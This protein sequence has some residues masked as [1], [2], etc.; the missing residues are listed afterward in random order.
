MPTIQDELGADG[1]D[2]LWIVNSFQLLLGALLLVGGSLG[3]LYGRKRIYA[4]GISVF[5]LASIACGLAPT[6]ETLI[7]ARIV[8]GIGGALMIPGSLAIISAYFD[9]DTRG[10]AIGIWAAFTTMTSVIGSPLG[11]LFAEIGF[12]RGVFLIN[13]PLAVIALYALLTHVPESY[14]ESSSKRLDIPGAV[15]IT[16]SLLA[17]VFGAT[18]IGRAGLDGF[19]NPVLVGP[20]IAGLIGVGGFIVIEA[21]SDHPMINLALFRSRTFS[22]ANL[23]TWFLYGALGVFLVFLPL[24]LVQV[25]G[26]GQFVAGLASLPFSI[27]LIAMSQW[28]GGLV[29]RIGPRPPLILGPILVGIGFILTALPGITDGESE[30]WTSFFPGMVVFGLGMGLTVSPLTA[31]AM[32]SVPQRNSGAAS[33]INNTMSRASGAFMTAVIGGF[34]LIVFSESLMSAV[35]DLDLSDQTQQALAEEAEQLSNTE[36]PEDLPDDVQAAIREDIRT[37]FVDTFRLVMLICAGLSFLSAGFAYWLVED[38]LRPA[39]IET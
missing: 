35:D 1:A 17:I 4:I 14:D 5:A 25:H 12:W 15:V 34:A 23:L 36:P 11:G 7:A 6:T 3:D 9:D 33:G 26:Y 28:A 24:N 10:R 16:L 38:R 2:V 22:G 19:T 30:Y 39:A 37:T 13:V 21:R 20:L 8:Q 32:G 31:T 29:D 18:E 27:L